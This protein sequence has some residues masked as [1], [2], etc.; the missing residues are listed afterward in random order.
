[1]TPDRDAIIER[2]D[3]F[4]AQ[5]LR[6]ARPRIRTSAGSGSESTA[7]SPV[8]LEACRL[9]PLCEDELHVRG[10]AGGGLVGM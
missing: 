6:V 5:Q 2:R 8:D 9:S 3:A 10:L 7:A 4:F 1:M